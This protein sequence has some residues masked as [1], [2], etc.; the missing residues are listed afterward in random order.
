MDYVLD[1]TSTDSKKRLY[2]ILKSLTGKRLIKIEKY[3]KKRS[4]TQNRYYHG[5]VLKY[6]AEATGFSPGEMHEVLK[7]KF[8]PYERANRVTGEMQTF[9]HSTTEL[10]TAE[11][12]EFLENVRVWAI[13]YL[14]C[15]IPLPNEVII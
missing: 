7:A 4:N 14:D 6:L 11:Y 12:E 3:S 10:N 1:T 15:L 8:L 2:D 5:V 9:G 13:N